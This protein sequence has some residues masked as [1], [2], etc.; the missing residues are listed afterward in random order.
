MR[1]LLSIFGNDN[2][3]GSAQWG[4]EKIFIELCREWMLSVGDLDGGKD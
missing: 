4:S 1:C 2:W 3:M